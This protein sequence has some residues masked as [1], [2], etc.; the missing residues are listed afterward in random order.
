M[1]LCDDCEYV[2]YSEELCDMHLKHIASVNKK[3][4]SKS[5]LTLASKHLIKRKAVKAALYGGTC[6][7]GTT[8]VIA[9]APLLGM[10]AIAHA[11]AIQ[12]SAGML[13][14]AVGALKGK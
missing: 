10:S 6:V 3:K 4:R 7:L 8:L 12:V 5:Q 9:S 14:S 11:V 13:G 2:G 1:S